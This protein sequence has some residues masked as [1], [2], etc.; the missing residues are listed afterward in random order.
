MTHKS[1][2]RI[3]SITVKQMADYDADTSFIG[4]FSRDAETEFAIDHRERG[5][6]G[7]D[8]LQWFNP[9]TVESFDPN[10]SWIPAGTKDKKAYWLKAMRHNAEQDYARMLQLEQGEFS[11]IGIRAEAKVQLVPQGVIQDITSGG[12]WGV[13]S[14]SGDYLGELEKEQLSELRSELH[15]A[16]FSNR[17]ITAAFR[18]VVRS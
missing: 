8:I 12:I 3:L 5:G 18:Q 6:H 7:K 11:F 9:A 1:M 13:E 4:E 2:K 17:A 14:D 16:G 15:A 10:A